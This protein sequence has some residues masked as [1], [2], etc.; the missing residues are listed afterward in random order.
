MRRI[1]LLISAASIA[2][3]GCSTKTQAP[4]DKSG[5]E[6]A[7]EASASAVP[8]P[9]GAPGIALSDAVVQL[10]AVPGRPAVAYFTLTPSAPAKGKLVAVHV[11]GFARAEMHE[12]KMEGGM[13]TMAPLDSVAIE[14]GKPITFA[15]GSNHV[16]LFDADGKLKA[17]DRTEL[18][19]TLDSGDKATIAASVK[20]VGEDM[21]TM[22]M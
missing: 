14:A 4:G 15:P 3:S 21:G 13:M 16:M 19:I 2:L 17:G 9:S 6:N 18:T 12:S 20:A 5:S 1:F 8:G 11:D 22:K 10:P 7:P